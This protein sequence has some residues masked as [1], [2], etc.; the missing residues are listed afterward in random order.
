MHT[1]QKLRSRGAKLSN[2]AEHEAWMNYLKKVNPKIETAFNSIKYDGENWIDWF[3]G[4]N[5]CN[6]YN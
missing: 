6:I 5:F 1:C 2:E 3:T 4:L